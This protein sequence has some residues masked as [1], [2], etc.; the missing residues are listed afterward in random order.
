MC[1]SV[2]EIV[3]ESTSL[4]TTRVHA[5]TDRSNTGY[6]PLQQWLQGWCVQGGSSHQ[7]PPPSSPSPTTP[8][9]PT[10]SRGRGRGSGRESR[11]GAS[12]GRG[13]G[14]GRGR[15]SRTPG[16]GTPAEVSSVGEGEA[17]GHLLLA[18]HHATLGWLTLLA[19]ASPL[20][21]RIGFRSCWRQT[22]ISWVKYLA[23][24]VWPGRHRHQPRDKLCYQELQHTISTV[25]AE[26]F[27]NAFLIHDKIHWFIA[28]LEHL[29]KCIW[30]DY[31]RVLII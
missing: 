19:A 21:S 22:E 16:A 23:G 15:G 3:S 8:G 6:V 9:C 27:R 7:R 28:I 14:R 30:T 20:M 26:S 24:V 18:G 1:L 12:W 10:P 5:A 17:P 2:V 13:R 4:A 29:N 25:T 11:T 31:F